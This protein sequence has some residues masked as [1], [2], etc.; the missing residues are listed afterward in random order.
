MARVFVTSVWGFEPDKWAGQGFSNAGTRDKLIREYQ[1]EDYL[2]LVATFGPEAKVEERGMLLGLTTLGSKALPTEHIVEPNMYRESRFQN[3]GAIKWPYSV[4]FN[5]AWYFE[6]PLLSRRK[7]LPRLQNEKLGMKIG[8]GFELLTNEEA[9]LVLKLP[10]NEALSV[11]KSNEML[12]QEE[13]QKSISK[14]KNGRNGPLP[15]FTKSLLEI[16]Y[17][18]ASVYRLEFIGDLSTSLGVDRHKLA[19][20]K[21]FKIGWSID[22]ENRKNTINNFMPNSEIFGWG[23]LNYHQYDSRLKAYAIEQMM[24]T[25][26]SDYRHRGEMILCSEKTIASVWNSHI[27]TEPSTE[28]L[29]S[30]YQQAML[31]QF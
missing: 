9:D 22:P 1:P 4:P 21:L 5:K 6:T 10:K 14:Q 19:G 17:S 16:E 20:K 12:E 23:K 18:P 26:L 7:L 29:S 11:Y 27:Y 2:L 15:S 8:T 3:N 13:L 25:A 24:L 28:G 30:G 31:S